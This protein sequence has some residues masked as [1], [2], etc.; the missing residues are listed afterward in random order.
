MNPSCASFAS[1]ITVNQFAEV[2]QQRSNTKVSR[3]HENGLILY[4]WYANAVRSAEKYQTRYD[5]SRISGSVTEEIT[6]EASSWL[7]EEFQRALS[8]FDPVGHHKWVALQD[9]P[10]DRGDPYVDIL[11]CFDVNRPRRRDPD[12]DCIIDTRDVGSRKVMAPGLISEDSSQNL[13]DG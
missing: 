10:A 1:L 3:D 6:C 7:D 12:P 4:D 13:K 2:G 8:T 5:V 9:V 11:A